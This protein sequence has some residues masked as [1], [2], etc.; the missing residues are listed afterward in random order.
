MKRKPPT[1]KEINETLHWV[2][3]DKLLDEMGAP[4]Q[5]SGGTL[6]PFGRL[7]RL[8]V[9]LT[10]DNAALQADLAAVREEYQKLR[11]EFDGALGKFAGDLKTLAQELAVA[12][13]N[14]DWSRMDTPP[15]FICGYA[16]P[17]YYQPEKHACARHYHAAKED[18]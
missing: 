11:E 7:K 10:A 14:I 16:G 17:G 1:N 9:K 13:K 15:C 4:K 8:R 18:K 3:L 5:V 12:K 6:S 2:M